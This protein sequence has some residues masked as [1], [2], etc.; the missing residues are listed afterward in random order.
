MI[1]D[2]KTGKKIGK[3]FEDINLD[4]K[5]RHKK[6]GILTPR[7]FVDALELEVSLIMDPYFPTII[8]GFKDRNEL[9]DW[10]ISNQPSYKKYI[11]EV[12]NYFALKY[13]I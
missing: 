6:L 4:R 12:V 1:V 2:L 3:T 10:C 9:K 7:Q 8:K 13:G 5:I 11:P